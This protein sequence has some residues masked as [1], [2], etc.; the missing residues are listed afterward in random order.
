MVSLGDGASY[1][2]SD[3]GSASETYYLQA[4]ADGI[5]SAAHNVGVYRSQ[6]LDSYNGKIL[7]IDPETGYGLPSNPHYLVSNPDAVQSKVWSLGVRNPFRM[8]KKPNTGSQV[9][10]DGDPGIFYFGDVGWGTREELNVVTGPN[11]NFGWPKYEVM[12]YHPPNYCNPVYAPSTHKLAAV[13]WRTGTARASV[14]GTIYNVGSSQ[15]PGPSFIDGNSSTGGVWYTGDDFPPEYKNTYFH[16]DYGNKWIHNFLFD[17]NDN[18]IEVKSFD[19][20]NGSVVFLSTSPVDGGLYYIRYGTAIH[21]ISY[22]PSGN[23]PPTAVASADVNYGPSPLIV[24]FTGDQSSDPESGLTYEWDF[25]NGPES[26]E[27]NPSYTFT[28]P[29]G[30][31]TSY[32]VRLTVMDDGSL[33]DETTLLISVN[34]CLTPPWSALDIIYSPSGLVD[35]SSDIQ[36]IFDVNCIGCHNE[37][38]QKLNLES[39][40][41]HDELWTLG[42][43]APYVDPEN[44]E[45]SKLYRHLT[46]DLLL[47]PLF[48]PLP[49]RE[50]DLVLKWITE[51]ALDN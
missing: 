4:I 45:Q 3:Q 6:L 22:L 7:R 38:H 2:S 12:T 29:L 21:K 10:S 14:N 39:C 11:Q 5:I 51:G 47:M 33:I 18:P 20:Q 42:A 41:S 31:P 34:N 48:G 40:C 15:V 30:V 19:S 8:T 16:A 27:A 13:D 17:S 35:F 26:T 36:P 24:Q 49:D 23:Q 9:P 43:G 28:A 44:P 25:G 37:G 50:I 46:G 32:T 1:A